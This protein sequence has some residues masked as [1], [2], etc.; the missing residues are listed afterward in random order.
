MFN[1]VLKNKHPV[2]APGPKRKKGKHM[3]QVLL[4]IVLFIILL[5]VPTVLNRRAVLQ[6]ITIFKKHQALDVD[7]AK[8]IA[9]LGLSPQTFKLRMLR[10]YKP[11]AVDILIKANIL[12]VTEDRKLYLLEKNIANLNPHKHA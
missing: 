11:R 4:V 6:V 1:R 5:A 2:R 8:T 7:R 12:A 3:L 10:D 9:E